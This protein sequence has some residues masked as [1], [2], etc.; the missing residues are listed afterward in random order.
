M[1]YL[2]KSMVGISE[3]TSRIEKTKLEKEFGKNTD[4]K[5]CSLLRP[6]TKNSDQFIVLKN[7]KAKAMITSKI[8]L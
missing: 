1:F 4:S 8:F 3:Y 5:C 6:S 2:F 7:L